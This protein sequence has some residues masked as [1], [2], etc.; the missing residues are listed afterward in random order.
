MSAVVPS[1]GK[2]R[3]LDSPAVPDEQI[4]PDQ[5]TDTDRIARLFMRILKDV[6]GLKRRY[7]PDRLDFEDVAVDATGTTLYRFP[8]GL[9]GRVRWWPVDW[10]GSLLTYNPA[11][12]RDPSTDDNTLV[13]VSYAAGIVTVRI[14]AAG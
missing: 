1:N 8:H 10:Q 4:T 2:L 7:W 13:L 6:A 3:Q 11:L 9:G 12:A 5:V 14:E